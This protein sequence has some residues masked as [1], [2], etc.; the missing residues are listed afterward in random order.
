MTIEHVGEAVAMRWRILALLVAV[1]IGLGFQ[2]QALGSVS[3]D[4]VA[5]FGLDYAGI[6]TL[7]GLFMLPGI[8]LALPAGF[9]GRYLSDRSLCCIGMLA[10]ALGGIAC[11]LAA[12]PW[13]IGF[14]R[15]VSGA[16]FLVSTLYF[17]KMTADWFSGREIATAMSALVMSWPLG[18]AL[19]QIGH[20]WI[21]Q[22]VGWRWTFLAAA[23]YCTLGAGALLAW[24]RSP[25]EALAPRRSEM[26]LLSRRELYLTLVAA[27]VWGIFNA[28][29]IVYLTFGPLMLEAH[30]LAKI[31]AAVVISIASWLMLLSGVACGQI[32]D[33][34]RR[35]DL[36]L[37]V[38]MVGAMASLALLKINGAGVAASLLFGVVGMA[39]AGVIMALTGE[40][41]SPEKRAFGMG[42]FL[43]A[44]FIINTV[45][46]PLAGWI[47]DVSRDPFSPIALGAGLFGLV[48]ANNAWFR[49]A[50]RQQSP[51]L[52]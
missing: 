31:K 39:P 21:A 17:T 4:L 15:A 37:A 42:V 26:S 2:F 8:F 36:T 49:V 41:M 14:G 7:V 43:S 25:E 48:I 5:A 1:R 9:C 47:Y 10:L 52:V 38:C 50:Q 29:Y 16:G 11:G 27:S 46:P 12:S 51:A 40:A 30:G 28:G 6:G 22:S 24:Y 13:M 45:V 34:T 19:G 18:I 32:A 23:A 44:Y 20:V 33:R 3:D 35:P